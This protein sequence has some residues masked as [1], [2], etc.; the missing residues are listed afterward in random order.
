MAFLRGS[1]E[2]EEEVKQEKIISKSYENL[3][4]F[5]FNFSKS[6]GFLI[7]DNDNDTS[8][9]YLFSTVFT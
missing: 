6:F 4:F 7:H 3:M 8:S 9:V 5:K 1:D 2:N